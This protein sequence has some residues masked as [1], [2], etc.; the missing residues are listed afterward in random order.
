MSAFWLNIRQFLQYPKYPK[1]RI[2]TQ[3]V[4]VPSR[5]GV[6]CTIYFSLA[7]TVLS[8]RTHVPNCIYTKKYGPFSPGECLSYYHKCLIKK[9]A[10]IIS[11]IFHNSK[12]HNNKH[13]QYVLLSP[14]LA[15][16]DTKQKESK[17]AI[18][19]YFCIFLHF[20]VTF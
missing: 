15:L 19:L 7:V 3:L 12:F 18:Y 20:F 5:R 10:C 13:L 6:L 1:I 11:L 9:S 16:L 4:Q 8:N 14:F 17:Q 2:F